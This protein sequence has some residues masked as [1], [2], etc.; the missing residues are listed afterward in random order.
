MAADVPEGVGL[1]D[2]L[3]V[4]GADGPDERA[5]RAE[6]RALYA[7]ERL[8]SRVLHVGQLE[9]RLKTAL[10]VISGWAWSLESLWDRFTDEERREAV[11]TIRRRAEAAI[12]DAEQLLREVQAE[13]TSL[14]LEPVEVDLAEAL[15][16][17][18]HTYGGTSVRHAVR[19]EGP[20]TVRVTVDPAALQQILGQ[21]LENAIKYS[22]GGGDVTLAVDTTESDV[23]IEVRD[24]GAG[25]PEGIDIFAPF[26]RGPAERSQ[27]GTGL[28]LYIVRSLVESMGGQIEARPNAAA[29]ATFTI[30]LPA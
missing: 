17:S 11:R 7:E 8:R 6:E 13:V 21:L 3:I 23:V 14:D 20:D 22:P 25:L 30:T 2:E 26:S 16:L 27:S 24:E 4:G 19:Y 15:R 28:G 10:G 5:Q 9:H 1:I 12:G 18:A 29:G